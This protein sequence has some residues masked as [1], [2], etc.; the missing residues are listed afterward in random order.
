MK[1]QPSCQIPKLS[2]HARAGVASGLPVAQKNASK[3]QQLEEALA[4]ATGREQR[5]RN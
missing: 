5:S 4:A 2:A 3:P 1:I